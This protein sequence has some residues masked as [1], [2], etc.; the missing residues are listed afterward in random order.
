MAKDDGN[1]IAEHVD[2]NGRVRDTDLN[3]RNKRAIMETFNRQEAKFEELYRM[4][5]ELTSAVKT[6]QNEIVL[7]KHLRKRRTD[8]DDALESRS[9]I[10]GYQNQ[11]WARLA[12][13]QE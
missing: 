10:R 3:E 12:K 5:R 11:P 13:V 6:L 4:N 8:S 9:L 7:L 1:N 2:D